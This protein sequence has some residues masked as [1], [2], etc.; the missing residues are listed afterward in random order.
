MLHTKSL[1]TKNI[2]YFGKLPDSA[3]FVKFNA[4]GQELQVLDKWL[5]DGIS[6]AKSKLKNNWR[7]FY[8]KS[9][10]LNFLY[11]FTGTK[12]LLIGTMFP[13]HDKSER[14]F[15]FLL[16]DTI[17]QSSYKN[18][19]S[20][21][22][23]LDSQRKLNLFNENIESTPNSTLLNQFGNIQI[24]NS[25]DPSFKKNYERFLNEKTAEEFWNSTL[26]DFSNH[27]K[28][29]VINNLY[30]NLSNLK[31]N[32]NII[33]SFGIRITYQ[34]IKS[35]FEFYL[36]FFL[37]LILTIINKPFLIPTILW[38]NNNDSGNLIYV[39]FSKPT[40]FNFLDLIHTDDNNERI[41]K[42]DNYESEEKLF[43]SIS[44]LHKTL[45]EK[46]ELKLNQL[47]QLI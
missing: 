36:T 10:P 38:T 23:L 43:E 5:Q 4:G 18:R 32:S 27:Q 37:H 15:P 40:P 44:S 1:S 3:D 12:N 29:A 21:I 11:S 47:L 25:V 20:Y 31:F 6:I 34:K 33:L 9:P 22:L 14:D 17:E 26:G 45:L 8:R 41:L 42:A 7:E 28:F 19:L 30:K 2:G 46:K 39:F 35:D 24:N 16:F 13:S